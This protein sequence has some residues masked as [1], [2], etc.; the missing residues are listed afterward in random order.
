MTCLLS[1]KNIG[2][3]QELLNDTNIKLNG[4]FT[5]PFLT[6]KLKEYSTSNNL[7]GVLLI[8]KHLYF[9]N[10]D[11]IQNLFFLLKDLKLMTSKV[12]DFRNPHSDKDQFSTLSSNDDDSRTNNLKNEDFEQ[13]NSSF[14]KT[15]S[16]K[17]NFARLGDDV[18]FPKPKETPNFEDSKQDNIPFEY[19]K[20]IS[21]ALSERNSDMKNIFE[22]MEQNAN[23][24][25][26]EENQV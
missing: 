17:T 14:S 6:N 24:P 13:N 8:N 3:L 2:L 25:M 20:E 22:K 23:I 16:E 5:E 9:Y 26:T 15:F 1:D 10:K 12:D 4:V 21:R 19:E 18:F 11:F 7:N